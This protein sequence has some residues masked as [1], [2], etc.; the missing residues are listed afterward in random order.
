MMSHSYTDLS[1]S[2]VDEMEDFYEIEEEMQEFEELNNGSNTPNTFKASIRE[3]SSFEAEMHSSAKSVVSMATEGCEMIISSVPESPFDGLTEALHM[4]GG[5]DIWEGEVT[6]ST[7]KHLL[8]Q[9]QIR[10]ANLAVGNYQEQFYNDM[11]NGVGLGERVLGA[12]ELQTEIVIDTIAIALTVATFGAAGILGAAG[13][14]LAGGFLTTSSLSRTVAMAAVGGGIFDS[15]GGI[16]TGRSDN[17]YVNDAAH[18]IQ[19][20]FDSESEEIE[21]SRTGDTGNNVIGYEGTKDIRISGHVEDV[22][23]SDGNAVFVQRHYYNEEG[24]EIGKCAYEYNDYQN[25]NPSVDVSDVKYSQKELLELSLDGGVVINNADREIPVKVSSVVIDGE[26]SHL[27]YSFMGNEVEDEIQL[28]AIT[29]GDKEA[30]EI[31]HY[32][33]NT[34]EIVYTEA[35]EHKTTETSFS[36]ASNVIGGM[37]FSVDEDATT[38]QAIFGAVMAGNAQMG[39][40]ERIDAM[41]RMNYIHNSLNALH[42]VSQINSN[43]ISAIAAFDFSEDESGSMFDIV[44]IGMDTPLSSMKLAGAELQ[45]QAADMMAS[46]SVAMSVFMAASIGSAIAE[47]GLGMAAEGAGSLMKEGSEALED[48]VAKGSELK[49]SNFLRSMTHTLE[50]EEAMRVETGLNNITKNSEGNIAKQSLDAEVNNFNYLDNVIP[51]KNHSRFLDLFSN[52]M[53]FYDILMD[54]AAGIERM[55]EEELEEQIF[56]GIA[57]FAGDLG[58][59]AEDVGD[60]IALETE[61][62]IVQHG[63]EAGVETGLEVGLTGASE[64]KIALATGE[65]VGE[66]LFQVGEEAAEKMAQ[67]GLEAELEAGAEVAEKAA[68]EKMEQETAHGLERGLVEERAEASSIETGVEDNTDYH[69]NG[70]RVTKAEYFENLGKMYEEA[71]AYEETLKLDPEGILLDDV[72]EG[73]GSN[74]DE[75]GEEGKKANSSFTITEDIE[76]KTISSPHSFAGLMAEEMMRGGKRIGTVMLTQGALSVISGN[77]EAQ[78]INFIA[79]EIDISEEMLFDSTYDALIKQTENA[80][81]NVPIISGLFSGKTLAIV[82]TSFSF[83]N[84]SRAI[85]YNELRSVREVQKTMAYSFEKES[86]GAVM[87]DIKEKMEKHGVTIDLKDVSNT[88]HVHVRTVDISS[89]YTNRS[90]TFVT[91]ELHDLEQK[92]AFVKQ[93]IISSHI[94]EG[95]SSLQGKYE[96]SRAFF[97]DEATI[98]QE[99]I[100]DTKLAEKLGFVIEDEIKVGFGESADVGL[101]GVVAEE[102]ITLAGEVASEELIGDKAVQLGEEISENI[103]HHHLDAGEEASV[104]ATE[105]IS[106]EKMEQEVVNSIEHGFIEEK[107]AVNSIEAIVEENKTGYH[108][109]EEVVT[110]EVYFSRLREMAEEAAEYEEIFKQAAAEDL[111]DYKNA[112][113]TPCTAE[114]WQESMAQANHE[115][116]LSKHEGV[117]ERKIVEET[118]EIAG[119]FERGEIQLNAVEEGIGNKRILVDGVEVS[120][121]KLY[122]QLIDGLNSGEYKSFYKNTNMNAESIERFFSTDEKFLQHI[123]M[124]EYVS[125]RMGLVFDNENVAYKKDDIINNFYDGEIEK[126]K[127]EPDA[128]KN[129]SG[130]ALSGLATDDVRL[131]TLNFI[132]HDHGGISNKGTMSN[133]EKA[134]MYYHNVMSEKAEK[135]NEFTTAYSRVSSENLRMASINSTKNFWVSLATFSIFGSRDP[136]TTDGRY[137]LQSM[138]LAGHIHNNDVFSN[139]LHSVNTGAP[140]SVLGVPLALMGHDYG[141]DWTA[142]LVKDNFDSIQEN[143]EFNNDYGFDVEFFNQDAES[144]ISDDEFSDVYEN[145]N[146][147]DGVSS[148]NKNNQE[149]GNVDDSI[150]VQN[151]NN[152]KEDDIDDLNDKN[153]ED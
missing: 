121:E 42:T 146:N 97:A 143:V 85:E 67:R 15:L 26:N 65:I 21:Y 57:G 100:N 150:I 140:M 38:Q 32:K 23:V 153:Q 144:G 11:E 3:F 13:M 25:L 12:T 27:T 82:A 148:F 94:K 59:A 16:G 47:K 63:L 68:I 49:T 17:E 134:E 69:I 101:T 62:K 28:E 53:R 40:Y 24:K 117:W 34:G 30:Y 129:N 152:V 104:I 106:I 56:Q 116:Y 88:G 14:S 39:L 44:K 33:T 54:G 130:R 132:E 35:I 142:D 50:E 10:M 55:G 41:Q 118:A 52:E 4:W 91:S 6:A 71:A 124:N 1:V 79:R 98:R 136:I 135:G 61:E 122:S 147:E 137:A 29:Y 145:L 90:K 125:N 87:N 64:G 76:N 66:R 22:L 127:A 139:V 131:R 8:G 51:E 105:S 73:I 149:F 81:F 43:V 83:G 96:V 151:Q 9:N 18:Y 141:K 19:H 86:F 46:V 48:V 89:G 109:G 93:E 133:H 119:G 80:L 7:E 123:S 74:L 77:F 37:S 120:G 72:E 92:T 110:E 84:I 107:G 128:W 45:L 108:I 138:R 70:E 112:D 126:Y 2:S 103:D 113:G 114:E 36:V 58:I 111:N 31:S 60:K 95:L 5:E 99:L 102:E 20:I 78:V 115:Q 75:V